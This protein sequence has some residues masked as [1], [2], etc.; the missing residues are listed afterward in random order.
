MEV[1][2]PAHAATR[3][4]GTGWPRRS[5][6]PAGW[7][8][9]DDSNRTCGIAA[10]IL[11]TAAEEMHLDAPPRRVTRPD[12]AVLPFALELELR[13]LPSR[14]RLEAAVRGLVREEVCS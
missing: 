13:A 2:R 1:L 9:I 7:W 6:R 5:P 8:S 4:T 12:V 3:S 14:D 11:A 10:E